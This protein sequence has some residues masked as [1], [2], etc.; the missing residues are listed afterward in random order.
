MRRLGRLF[1]A[2]LVVREANVCLAAC[3]CWYHAAHLHVRGGGCFSC[4]E[5]ISLAVELSSRL[6]VLWACG[7]FVAC[8]VAAVGLTVAQRPRFAQPPAVK[9]PLDAPAAVAVASSTATGD[10]PLDASL[11]W[12]TAGIAL[13]TGLAFASQG[14]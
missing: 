6:A 5:R 13:A 1:V 12:A 3:L 14:A 8:Q 2:E 9:A 11:D 10:L 7:L 4:G